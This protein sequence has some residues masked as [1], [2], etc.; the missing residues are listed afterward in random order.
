MAVQILNRAQ[1]FA[2]GSDL[3]VVP[4]GDE[5]PLLKRMDWYLN[6]QMSRARRHISHDISPQLKTIIND[7]TMPNFLPELP[8]KTALMIASE[9][10]FPVKTIVEIPRANKVEAWVEKVHEIWLKLDRPALRVFLPN[11]ITPAE[12]QD[13]WPGGKADPISLVPA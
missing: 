13:F 10:H 4:D 5:N 1:A 2:S 11:K 6:F 8:E 3:W 7:N 12:Y 9:N